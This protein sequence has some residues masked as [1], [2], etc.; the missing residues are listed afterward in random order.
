[1]N[2]E[3]KISE[4]GSNQEHARS[5]VAD[6]IQGLDVPVCFYDRDLRFVFGNDLFLSTFYRESAPVTGD[7]A[8]DSMRRQVRRGIY[9]APKGMTDEAFI[10]DFIT[11]LSHFAKDVRIELTSGKVLNGASHDSGLGVFM[12][13]FRD[14]TEAVQSEIQL[15]QQRAE[16]ERANVR[17]R[18][19]LDSIGEGFALYDHEDR[20]ILTNDRFKT[21]NQAAADLMTPGRPRRDVIAAMQAGGDILN[22]D[23]LLEVYDRDH[24]RGET[25]QS[26]RTELLHADGRVFLTSRSPTAEGGC[27]I[28]WLDITDSKKT[29]QR[30]RALVNDAME[31]LDEGFALFDADLN[32][33][34]CNQRY[35]HLA[36]G[37]PEFIPSAGTSMSDLVGDMHQRDLYAE[38]SIVSE[39]AHIQSMRDFAL[40]Y[41]KNAEFE[42]T[43]R[44]ILQLSSHK[45]ALGGYLL[46]A[47][48]VTDERRAEEQ[49]LAKLTDT[50]Q[51]LDTGLLLWDA[52]LNFVFANDRLKGEFNNGKNA[53]RVGEPITTVVRR[54][55]ES[56]FYA[57]P[58]GMDGE[59][60]VAL[61][62]RMVRE[63]RRGIEIPA[64]DGRT[65]R[66]SAYPTKDD[67]RVVA[68]NDVTGQRQ[69]EAELA[70]QR[71]AAHQN[72]KLSAMGELL[73][74]VAHELNNPLS[75]VVGY[76]MML[77]NAELD[78]KL[79]RQVD[80][81]AQAAE[82]CARIVKAFLAMARQRPVE[83]RRCSL[84]ELM[85]AAVDMVGHRLRGAG[86]EVSIDLDPDLPDVE[87]DEDQIIQVF[88]NL[89]V[90][91]EQALDGRPAPRRL[92]L[93]S[94]LDRAAGKAVARISDNG[95][96]IEP[97]VMPR[98]FEPFF[99]TKEVGTG[100]GIGLAFSHRVVASH[101]GRMTVR[102]SPGKGARFYIRLALCADL[103]TKAD[104]LAPECAPGPG[105][106]LV[107]DDEVRVAELLR[108]VLEEAGHQ[109]QTLTSPEDALEVLRTQRYDAIISDMKMP[110][111]DGRQ[112]HNS[113]YQIDPALARRTG[114]VTGDSMS[115]QVAE[116]L[117]RCGQPHLEKPV[118]PREILTLVAGLMKKR[119]T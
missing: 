19:A 26:R 28:T 102:S 115:R 8:Y 91:A 114:F 90:N 40:S 71:E 39:E 100:T 81:V 98:I 103:E 68:F 23:D 33:V 46:T 37:G 84:N 7:S 56:G 79:K 24:A 47:R 13:T 16:T 29:E 63:M 99:T 92:H 43:D 101:G 35:A 30:A 104:K 107:V 60:Y 113:L 4:A 83:L 36:L 109:V 74:G 42:R 94:F 77:Q 82:R 21:A 53:P 55:V 88:T 85:M 70:R 44:S 25:Q 59:S 111:M 50:V 17:L 105:R 18:D 12:I 64:A 38:P 96:G 112:F 75:V 86:I 49:A 41:G 66:L 80:N 117:D 78:P 45:T 52:D 97:E 9:R 87:A 51:A 20:L 48:D 14:I 3:S 108:E 95:P 89:L 119:S 34:F 54:L 65:F 2:R 15:E 58:D 73:A 22:A 11:R 10:D 106:V 57:L 32:F 116:F 6:A 118:T 1:M 62:V 69:A 67:G 5:M 93:R 76:A 61:A 27:T 31:A 110:G 72:E